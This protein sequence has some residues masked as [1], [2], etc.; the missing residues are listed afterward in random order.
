VN[1]IGFLFWRGGLVSPHAYISSM[2][3][4]S[5]RGYRVVI[6]KVPRNLAILS[7]NKGLEISRRLG[8]EWVAGGHSLGG[9][10]AAWS[11]HDHPSAFKGLVIMASFPSDDKGLGSRNIP[12]LSL[13]AEKDGLSPPADILANASLLPSATV[14][15]RIDGGNHA[16][17]GDY[18]RQDGDRSADIS[19]A[20]Q[21]SV[22]ANQLEVFRS[23]L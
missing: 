4:F 12:V 5:R 6:A 20:Q 2:A 15:Y 7:V 1:S 19:P 22:M 10:A 18:G 21:H 13:Y 3:E 17:F 23:G 9:V 11:L 14:F 16:G 8:G